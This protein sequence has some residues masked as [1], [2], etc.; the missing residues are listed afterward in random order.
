MNISFHC[1]ASY[2]VPFSNEAQ[3]YPFSYFSP[4]LYQVF[5][6]QLFKS[7]FIVDLERKYTSSVFRFQLFF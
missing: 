5:L 7:I 1:I 4:N 3:S 2:I 6:S